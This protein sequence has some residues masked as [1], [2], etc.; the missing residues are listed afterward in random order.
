MDKIIERMQR[1]DGWIMQFEERSSNSPLVHVFFRLIVVPVIVFYVFIYS[2][3]RIFFELIKKFILRISDQP[4]EAF[5]P[6]MEYETAL[7]LD[8]FED[9]VHDTIFHELDTPREEIASK[10]LYNSSLL[11]YE[12]EEEELSMTDEILMSRKKYYDEL[13]E[14][15][16]ICIG[17][18][19]GS[20]ADA[21]LATARHESL[22]SSKAPPSAPPSPLQEKLKERKAIEEEMAK[23][24]DVEELRNKI[25]N[26]KDGGQEIQM[27]MKRK[28]LPPDEENQN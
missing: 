27:L 24:I 18:A 19:G 16:D 25:L 12:D 13:K 15:E 22:Y 28:P 17:E 23:N 21:E 9:L 1:L 11:M 5:E 3:I 7:S 2:L 20:M 4:E 14:L 6:V 10:Y 26:P 8:S